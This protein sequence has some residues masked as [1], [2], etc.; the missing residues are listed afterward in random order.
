[1]SAL[2][3][4]PITKEDFKKAGLPW[5]VPYDKITINDEGYNTTAQGIVIQIQNLDYHCVY[6]AEYAKVKWFKP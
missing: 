3:E 1:M 5:I 4:K 6:P 2:K